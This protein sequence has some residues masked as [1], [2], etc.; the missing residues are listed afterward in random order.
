MKPVGL[1]EFGTSAMIAHSFRTA[2][3]LWAFTVTV[4]AQQ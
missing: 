2:T 1:I 4:L 3:I